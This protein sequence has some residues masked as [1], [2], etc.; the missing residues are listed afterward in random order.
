MKND[1]NESGRHHA[2][3]YEE[4]QEAFGLNLIRAR[5]VAG[6]IDSASGELQQMQKGK[7][8]YESDLSSGTVT[9]LTST[10]DTQDIKPDL[11]TICKLGHALN[12]S[13]AF[14]LMTSRDWSFLLQALK[15]L[16]DLTDPKDDNAMPLV[17][18]LEE[19]A[20][21]QNFNDS[22]MAGLRFMEAMR[23]ESYSK[24]DLARQQMSILA[25]TAIAQGSVKRQGT[26]LKM[27]ATA[28]GA[29]LGD[30][31]ISHN[32]PTSGK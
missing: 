14:L 24:T 8:A 4:V 15:M 5:R 28:L 22:V 19:A 21:D 6:G 31:E 9:K 2:G 26:A 13:P 11:E 32:Q 3:L 17:K 1:N 23:N 18:I 7:L 29:I 20:R 25:M 12:I 16:Q 27:Y 10:V 30:R